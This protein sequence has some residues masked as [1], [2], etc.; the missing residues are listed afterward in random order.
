[1]KTTTYEE[2]NRQK[3]PDL[4]DF[5]RKGGISCQVTKFKN[6]IKSMT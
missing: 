1:M 5:R 4:V 3:K 6:V 2:K